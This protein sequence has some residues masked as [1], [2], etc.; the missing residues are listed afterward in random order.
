M[1]PRRK[2]CRRF[3]QLERHRAVDHRRGFSGKQESDGVQTVVADNQL[4]KT[5][6][7]WNFQE[8]NRLRLAPGLFSRHP[9][10]LAA[11]VVLPKM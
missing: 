7:A 8:G 4:G 1:V 6:S 9:A 2:W 5:L 3:I 10:D 11:F